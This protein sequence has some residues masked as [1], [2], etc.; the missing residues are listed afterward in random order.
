MLGRLLDTRQRRKKTG[1]SIS[2]NIEDKAE[3]PKFQKNHQQ[4]H[5]T[6]QQN[7]KQTSFASMS[8][9][10]RFVL[11]LAFF[12]LTDARKQKKLRTVWF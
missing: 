7:K 9:L 2:E 11:F 1:I 5:Q 10:F 3:Q 6:R 12:V 8:C 4:P